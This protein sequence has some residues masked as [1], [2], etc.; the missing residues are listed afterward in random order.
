M[1]LTTY[2]RDDKYFKVMNPKYWDTNSSTL[3]N[4]YRLLSACSSSPCSVYMYTPLSS[5]SLPTTLGLD[6][7]FPI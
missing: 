5:S 1:Q 2:K 3:G 7:L 6:L 4:M